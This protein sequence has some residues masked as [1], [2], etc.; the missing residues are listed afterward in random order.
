MDKYMCSTNLITGLCEMV[1]TD[2]VPG[3]SE[4][5]AHKEWYEVDEVDARDANIVIALKEVQEHHR[6]GEEDMILGECIEALKH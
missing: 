2:D 3:G 6:V 4:N 5:G 1:K